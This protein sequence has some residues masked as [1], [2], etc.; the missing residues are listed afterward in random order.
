MLSRRE[1][2]CARHRSRLAGKWICGNGGVSP[3]CHSPASGRRAAPS[4]RTATTIT[5]ATPGGC[6]AAAIRVAGAADAVL[7]S[8]HTAE[9]RLRL[10]Q[11]IAARLGGAMSLREIL[12]E[13]AEILRERFDW[14]YVGCAHVDAGAGL[15]RYDRHAAAFALPFPADMTQPIGSGIIGEV[16]ASG[17]AQ[18][19]DDVLQHANYVA[20]IPSTRA[21]LCVPVLFQGEPIAVLDAQSHRPAAFSTD[22]A[23]TLAVIAELL[24]GRIAA[25]QELEAAR[26]RADVI[27][28]LADVAR[29]MLG[30][31]QLDAMLQRLIDELHRR[32]E[33]TLSTLCLVGA[34]P[35]EL[36][37]HAHAGESSFP[38]QRGRRW[39]KE[40]GVTGRAVR[41]RVRLFVPDVRQDPDYIEGNPRSVSEL[42]VPIRFRGEALGLINLESASRSA[43]SPA[44]QV[45]VQA[46]A[47]QAA[48]AIRLALTK[49]RLLHVNE[50]ARQVAEQ[51]AATN[52]RLETANRKLQQMSLRD[53]LTGLGNRRSFDR[54]LRDGWR[55]GRRARSALALLLIDVDHY[56]AFNDR[57]GHAAGDECLQRLGRLL[58]RLARSPAQASRYGGEEFAVLI[59][60]A[61]LARATALAQRIHAALHALQLPHCDS[62]VTDRLSVSIGVACEMPGGLREPGDLLRDAD[63]ALYAAKAAGRNRTVVAG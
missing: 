48:G 28:L 51:L 44:N 56:K 61:T 60:D 9:H 12:A 55:H 42:V 27:E 58:R 8:S 17:R 19:I 29:A 21:E 3:G 24:A 6:D 11:D 35:D 40:S 53:P 16:A 52:R 26:Q 50:Q 10:M 46:L 23:A 47:D 1:R 43:F 20:L 15:V 37:L 63:A 54:A 31:D 38:L 32:L 59:P 41:D 62:P 22:D 4:G 57:Y 34:A 25:A 7:R 36:I 33:L 49:Q 5:V 18:R 39:P 2:G 45:A 14:D 13:V 30:E